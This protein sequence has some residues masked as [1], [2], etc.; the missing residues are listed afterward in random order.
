[1]GGFGAIGDDGRGPVAESFDARAVHR[2]LSWFK[3]RPGLQPLQLRHLGGKP[4]MAKA[5]V[6][7]TR[8]Q[9]ALKTRLMAP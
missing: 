6:G 2:S 3:S 1:L 5:A 4:M 8:S 7:G 9:K